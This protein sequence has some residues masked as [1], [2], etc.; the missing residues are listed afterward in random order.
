MVLGIFPY[1]GVAVV[2]I[3]GCYVLIGKAWKDHKPLGK[4]VCFEAVA[5]PH[6][7]QID[8]DLIGLGVV[9]LEG[10]EDMV[11]EQIT[12][13]LACFESTEKEK[14]RGQVKNPFI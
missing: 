11:D 8:D 4:E 1:P 7:R 2:N 3:D 6:M 5:G 14:K 10:E 12:V 13:D 9:G